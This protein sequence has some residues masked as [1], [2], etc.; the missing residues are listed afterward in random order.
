MDLSL[1][2]QSLLESYVKLEADISAMALNEAEVS[3][4]YTKQ[5]PNYVSFKRQQADLFAQ[6]ERLNQK[7]GSLPET[8]QK[9]LTLMRDF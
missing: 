6:R 5:H 1:E 9:I 3:R 4:R 2:T 7:I 8:Q